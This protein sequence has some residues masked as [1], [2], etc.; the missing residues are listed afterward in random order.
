LAAVAGGCRTYTTPRDADS[1]PVVNHARVVVREPA[2][3][4]GRRWEMH[5]SLTTADAADRVYERLQRFGFEVYE[6]KSD[7]FAASVHATGA[8]LRTF[9]ATFR[10]QREGDVAVTFESNFDKRQFDHVVA[11][12]SGALSAAAPTSAPAAATPG[13]LRAHP[14]KDVHAPG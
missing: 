1:P 7:Y 13:D 5:T 2:A 3:E 9:T 11:D 6:G 12:L 8:N 10:W 4:A 14:A